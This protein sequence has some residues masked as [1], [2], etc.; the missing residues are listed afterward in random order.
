M[1]NTNNTTIENRQPEMV[2]AKP[3]HLPKPTYW[4]FFAA[5]G[6]LLIGWGLLSL[7]LF[8]V[9]GLIVFV[10]SLTGWIN[11]MRHE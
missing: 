10:I 11:C 7:W 2:K 8:S 4:P 5:L 1:E 9:V 6:L 3:E